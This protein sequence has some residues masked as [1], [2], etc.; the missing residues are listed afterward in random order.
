[1]RERRLYP[2]YTL[3]RVEGIVYFNRADYIESVK[4]LKRALFD[5]DIDG[6]IPQKLSVLNMLM[7][8]YYYL[9]NIPSMEYYVQKLYELAEKSDYQNYLSAAVFGKGLVN[10][11]KCNKIIAYK[12]FRE[13]IRILE[14]IDSPQAREDLFYR[15]LSLLEH[16]QE[17]NLNTEALQTIQTIEAYQ[18][19]RDSSETTNDPLND[20]HLKDFLA[21]CTVI[22]QRLGH[23]N[24][25]GMDIF[26]FTGLHLFPISCIFSSFKRLFSVNPSDRPYCGEANQFFTCQN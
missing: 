1:M 10:H 13:S 16:Q 7:Y 24:L 8:S 2:T 14:N 21:H 6:D 25:S 9:H 3:N 23:A 17:D 26:V 15:Y 20:I 22:Y 5:K 19:S 12:H 4:F 11:A 18:A